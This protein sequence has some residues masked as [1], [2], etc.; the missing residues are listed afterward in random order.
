MR[1]RNH[2]GPSKKGRPPDAI[3]DHDVT[4]LLNYGMV[5]NTKT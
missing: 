1:I 5:K 4:D 3:T 2:L